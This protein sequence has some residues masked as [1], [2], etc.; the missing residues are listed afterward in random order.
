MSRKYEFKVGEII[1]ELNAHDI[2]GTKDWHSNRKK[3]M[4]LA[5]RRGF[6]D[7]YENAKYCEGYHDDDNV[8]MEELKGVNEY[9]VYRYEG[10]NELNEGELEWVMESPENEVLCHKGENLRG[11]FTLMK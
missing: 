1:E 2:L 8:G 7:K 4:V 11:R 5:R 10:N 9:L 3:L 6:T